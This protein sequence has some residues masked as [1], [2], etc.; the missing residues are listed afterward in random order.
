MS[1]INY[2]EVEGGKIAYRTFGPED[3][4]TVIYAP[5]GITANMLTWTALSEQLEDALII[6][7]DLR[8]RGRS[9]SLG[10]P[11][12]LRQHALDAIAILDQLQVSSYHI[13]GH[14]MG[15]FVSVLLAAMDQDRVL[16]VTLVDGGL[17]LIRPAGIS[18]EN[19]VSA[20]LGP[21]AQ[22]LGM[23][24][25]T[26]AAYLEFWRSHP[27]F[28]DSW[29]VLIEDYLRHDLMAEGEVFRPSASLD[30]VSADILELFGAE[31]Y[32]AA[33]RVIEA[34]VLFIRA[35]R[36]LLN[37]DPLYS[38]DLSKYSTDLFRD[39]VSVESVDVNHY[40]ILLS[41]DG[42]KQVAKHFEEKTSLLKKVAG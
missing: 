29:G 39:F 6:A 36:G 26:E 22:R 31:D 27:A 30:A 25:E 34:P 1:N 10:S 23:K 33:M 16:S 15:G 40:T 24:F 7:P 28:R 2:V 8:G 13:V 20:T 42:A 41:A 38:K 37:E 5:H 19:I 17:P 32:L 18:D 12:G 14:S 3:A 35:P 11:F 9:N 21:A 4:Q